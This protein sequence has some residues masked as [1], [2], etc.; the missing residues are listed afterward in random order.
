MR[1]HLDGSLLYSIDYF[2]RIGHGL[3]RLCYG[4]IIDNGT[5]VTLDSW[6][7]APVDFL[8]P[9]S[10]PYVLLITLPGSVRCRRGNLGEA[11]R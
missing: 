4:T 2:P 7:E 3:T 8:N 6:A 11:S 10:I 9:L 5:H 1:Y